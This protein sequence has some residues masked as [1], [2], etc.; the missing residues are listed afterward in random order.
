[1]DG[2]EVSLILPTQGTRP[3]FARALRSALAQVFPS[4]E[5]IVIDDGPAGM[6][7]RRQEETTRLLTD[8]RVRI[9]DLHQ[10]RGCA[11]AKNVGLRAARGTWV[12]YLD[13]D[14][15]YR[16]DKVRLQHALGL[17]SGSLLVLCGIEVHV[18]GRRRRRQVDCSF[19][20]GDELL[21][22]ALPDTNTLFHRRKMEV[23]WDETIGT[24]DDAC[25]FQ[26][27]LASTGMRR[28]PNIG[29]PLVD[30]YAHS[31]PR[32]NCD[33]ERV[34]RGARRLV[35]RWTGGYSVRARR[36]CLLRALVASCKY[37]K[38]HWCRL[39]RVGITL[40]RTG[41]W[42]EWRCVANAIG[43]KVPFTRR[44]MIT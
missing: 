14:N 15:E 41:G 11:A 24:G 21:L 16:P 40:L 26:A 13:D 20:E 9:I 5:V 31:G 32:M 7:W 6:D 17:D 39:I 38:G 1:M 27:F 8:P 10:G 12:C 29:Y 44:M 33:H 23:A 36:I 34:Y 19:F 22:R 18:A 30:Y 43:V 37:R 2:P 42:R 25:F 3:S 28:V 4:L 35:V